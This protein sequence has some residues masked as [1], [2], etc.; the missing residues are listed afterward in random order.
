MHEIFVMVIQYET[1]RDT[2][3]LLPETLLGKMLKEENSQIC[4]FENGNELFFDRNGR[5]FHYIL[6]FYRTGKLLWSNHAHYQQ[7][8]ENI[9]HECCANMV[10]KEEIES[11]IDFFQL[12]IKLPLSLPVIEKPNPR[13][14]MLDNFINVF[15]TLISTAKGLYVNKI[16][17]T[18]PCHA[19]EE[20]YLEPRIKMLVNI[21][22]PFSDCGFHLLKNYGEMIGDYL[23][24][25][26]GEL[27]CKINFSNVGWRDAK[28]IIMIEI[29]PK[30][31]V[32]SVI[33][34]SILGNSKL[35][36]EKLSL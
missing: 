13:V 12:P 6:E 35:V 30:F 16:N 10:T 4:K 3:L 15:E 27:K 34:G 5:A 22:H 14:E 2:L 31:D 1:F 9:L 21:L 8:F 19:R 18:F 26:D 7:T 11:E 33:S 20:F 28:C 36:K 32:N 17:I 23:E 29:N 25:N 24:E